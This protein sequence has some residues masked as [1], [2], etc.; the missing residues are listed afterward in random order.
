MGDQYHGHFSFF[1]DLMYQIKDVCF[2][3]LIQSGSGLIC[4]QKQGIAG[5]GNGD[6]NTLSHPA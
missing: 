5:N 4:D 2:C 3:F 1:F 6:Q